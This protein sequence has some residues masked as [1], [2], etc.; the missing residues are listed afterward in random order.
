M[1]TSFNKK[2]YT[3][4]K[5]NLSNDLIHFIT[6]YVFYEEKSTVRIN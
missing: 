2:G 6:K 1:P 4:S 5:T 3:K